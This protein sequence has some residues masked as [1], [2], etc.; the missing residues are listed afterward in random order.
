ML[1]PVPYDRRRAVEYARRWALSRNPLFVNFA[2]QGG[3]CT[4]FVS[5]CILAGCGIM[6]G[7]VNLFVMILS[8]MMSVSLMFPLMSVGGILVTF[9]VSI[10]FYKEKLTRLQYLGFLAGIGAVIFLNI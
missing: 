10:L 7:T 6:N 2:G 3:D 9:T 5:Q 8:G 1:L 4:S